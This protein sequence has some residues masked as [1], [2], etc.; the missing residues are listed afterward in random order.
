MNRK[1]GKEEGK[2]HKKKRRRK[3][4][5]QTDTHMYIE[6]VRGR[7]ID[8]IKKTEHISAVSWLYQKIDTLSEYTHV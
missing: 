7:D 2:K 4:E 3:G 6:R 1:R 8:G 5:R